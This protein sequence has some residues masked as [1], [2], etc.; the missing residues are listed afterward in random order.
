MESKV[1]TLLFL[2]FLCL[3]LSTSTAFNITRILTN[4]PEFDTFNN[5]LSQTGLAK[6]I[7][8]RSTV[9]V[10]AVDN[11]VAG[12][13][14][15]KPEDILKRILSAHVILDYYDPLKISKLAKK[16]TTVTTLYQASGMADD[17]QGFGSSQ[18]SQLIK[19]VTNQPYNVSVLQVS[20]VI[21]AAGIDG[22]GGASPTKSP[23]PPPAPAETPEE[24]PAEA[25]APSSKEA[26]PTETPAPVPAAGPAVD[27]LAD[28]PSDGP[29]ADGPSEDD[30]GT[31]DGKTNK[32]YPSTSVG[33]VSMAMAL[34]VAWS[35]MAL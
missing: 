1:V 7:N 15:G 10:L 14:A 27:A 30:Q 13:V 22:A 18:T 21:E 5:I 11:G 6:E 2:V 24:S 4:Y 16:I 20:G 31:A 12:G 25:P 29:A 17:Q 32:G 26:P 3:N 28:A 8:S 33:G 35:M 34:A 19:S 9:T 23:S